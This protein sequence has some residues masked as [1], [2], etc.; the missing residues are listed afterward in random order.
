MWVVYVYVRKSTLAAVGVGGGEILE[1]GYMRAPPDTSSPH[2]GIVLVFEG[3]EV[4]YPQKGLWLRYMA[5][6]YDRDETC[7][8]ATSL[9]P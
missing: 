3:V 5:F 9:G 4:L 7:Y 2:L 1:G 8:A 6:R